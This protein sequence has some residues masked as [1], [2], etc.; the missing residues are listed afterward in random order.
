MPTCSHQAWKNIRKFN[1]SYFSF[2]FVDYSVGICEGNEN[3]Y[4]AAAAESE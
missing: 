1:T 2:T 3:V 4:A